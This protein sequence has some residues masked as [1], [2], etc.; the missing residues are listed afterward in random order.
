MRPILLGLASSHREPDRPCL[1]ACASRPEISRP[2]RRVQGEGSGFGILIW[3]P[4][5]YESWRR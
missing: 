5:V 1:V 3:G 2:L 4:P